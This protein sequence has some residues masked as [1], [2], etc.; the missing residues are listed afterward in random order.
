[1]TDAINLGLEKRRRAVDHAGDSRLWTV[2]D[3]LNDVLQEIGDQQ[4]NP[5]KAVLILWEDHPTMPHK[6][7]KMW[8]VSGVTA[9]SAIAMS[10]FYTY[11]MLKSMDSAGPP[12]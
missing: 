6:V 7:A 10:Q 9:E 4:I 8:R 1:M 11:E 12:T 2:S 3:M 5:N